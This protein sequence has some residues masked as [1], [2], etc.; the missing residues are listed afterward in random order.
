M[1]ETTY[2]NKTYKI[3][4]KKLMLVL[5]KLANKEISEQEII[6][7][8]EKYNLMDEYFLENVNSL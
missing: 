5:E 8:M 3:D 7:L 6:E 4:K 2:K 1:I